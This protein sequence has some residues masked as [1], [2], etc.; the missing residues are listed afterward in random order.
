MSLLRRGS[1]GAEPKPTGSEFRSA[2][3]QLYA[4]VGCPIAG[5]MEREPTQR[6]VQGASTAG[7]DARFAR[8]NQNQ[9]ELRSESLR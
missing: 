8:R 4:A 7:R 3:T 2:P 1:E 5:S 6:C 9:R